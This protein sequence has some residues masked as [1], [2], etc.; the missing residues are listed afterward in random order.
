MSVRFTFK[1]GV[2]MSNVNDRQK[3]EQ[4]AYQIFEERGKTNGSDF[5]DWLRAEREI[6]NQEKSNKASSKKKS[7]F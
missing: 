4:R 1:K 2:V 6:M 7:F 3:I 5:D